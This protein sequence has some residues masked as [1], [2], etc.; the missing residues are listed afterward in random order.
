M[1]KVIYFLPFLV[2]FMM[3]ST[4]SLYSQEGQTIE[5]INKEIA[6]K[7]NES[8]Q[9]LTEANQA[10]GIGEYDKAY[11]LAEKARQ[12]TAEADA[13]KLKK[14]AFLKIEDAKTAIADAENQEAQKYAPE[15]LA[16]AKSSLLSAQNYY[17]QGNFDSALQSAEDS[18]NFANS[19]IAKIEEAKKKEEEARLQREGELTAAETETE[20]P[21]T[22]IKGVYKIMKSYTVRLIPHRRDCLWRI[23]EYKFIYGNPWKWPVI[24]KANKEQIK[25]PDL[26]YPGQIFDIP[27]LDANGKPI[28]VEESMKKEESV[29]EE[30]TEE[31]TTE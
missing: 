25:D 21:E 11:D 5:D 2:I 12:I 20:V 28:L 23:A 18:I 14:S 22:K 30:T 27:E 26:I 24:Y 29:E 17:D 8:K 6:T 9:V 3:I 4:P 13:L 15:E 19:S 7:V 1:K 16:N 31:E 10:V